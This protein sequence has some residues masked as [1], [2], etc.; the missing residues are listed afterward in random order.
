[1]ICKFC[2]NENNDSATH[3][4]I[5]GKALV[6]AIATSLVDIG[7]SDGSEGYA[8]Q[9]Q[10]DP[11]ANR[12]ASDTG[13]GPLVGPQSFSAQIMAGESTK[14]GSGV[15]GIAFVIILLVALLAAAWFL[16]LSQNAPYAD[17]LPESLR[18][19]SQKPLPESVE[20][21]E[22]AIFSIFR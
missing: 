8:I 20:M 4:Y 2:G 13:G 19:F 15:G 10:N 18:H 12:F 17:M 5:C 9:N 21:V 22:G 14:K 1:M 6:S 11:H 16:F 7:T 3:C